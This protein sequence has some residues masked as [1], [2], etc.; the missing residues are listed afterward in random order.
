MQPCSSQ[1]TGSPG[2]SFLPQLPAI[3]CCVPGTAPSTA[4]PYHQIDP[5]E[6]SVGAS[7]ARLFPMPE[8][9]LDPEPQSGPRGIEVTRPGKE[10]SLWESLVR[11]TFHCPQL[12]LRPRPGRGGSDRLPPA[13]RPDRETELGVDVAT[14]PEMPPQPLPG[15]EAGEVLPPGT[16]S[17]LRA[18][19][20]SGQI[21][22][23]QAEPR[24]GHTRLPQPGR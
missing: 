18:Q 14:K 16:L 9:S 1:V 22:R 17:H 2:R 12:C 19:K 6:R 21:N 5:V 24:E 15:M 23:L 20:C 11:V 3:T 13:L 8:P 10:F 7:L 4:P